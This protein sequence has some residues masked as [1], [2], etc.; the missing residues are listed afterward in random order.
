MGAAPLRFLQLL[1]DLVPLFV[2]CNKN[3][4]NLLGS[5]QAL[6]KHVKNDMQIMVYEIVGFF[7]IWSYLFVNLCISQS[8]KNNFTQY[9]KKR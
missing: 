9:G 5:I 7:T 4:V 8:K 3:P 2:R 6:R 1:W